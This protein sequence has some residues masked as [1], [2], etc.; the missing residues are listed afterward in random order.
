MASSGG[1]VRHRGGQTSKK[2]QQTGS[3]TPTSDFSVVGGKQKLEKASGSEWD[4]K[5][6]AVILTVLAFATRFYGISHPDQVVFDEVHFG[7]VSETPQSISSF[8]WELIA[9]S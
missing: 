4:F 1:S 5:L 7:K 6:T 2:Y 8:T 9:D 3:E